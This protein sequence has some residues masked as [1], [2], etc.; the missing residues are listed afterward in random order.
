MTVNTLRSTP[1]RI[2]QIGESLTMLTKEAQQRVLRYECK[3]KRNAL[4]KD[5]DLA[6]ARDK[7]FKVFQE[8]FA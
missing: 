3:S 6:N 5:F 2:R 8:G 1:Q 7:I 4:Q